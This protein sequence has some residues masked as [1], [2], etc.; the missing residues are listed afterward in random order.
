MG[1]PFH[2]PPTKRIAGNQLVATWNVGGMAPPKVMEFPKHPGGH[3][4]L[5]P[6]KPPLSQLTSVLLQD[7]GSGHLL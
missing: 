5:S 2:A 6:G 3:K 4:T 7:R 1:D